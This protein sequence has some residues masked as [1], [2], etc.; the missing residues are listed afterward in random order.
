M[1][2]CGG[3]SVNHHAEKFC[4]CSEELGKA[5]VQLQTKRIDQAAFDKVRLEQEKCM[6]ESNPLEKFKNEKSKLEFQAAFLKAIFEQCPNV[7]RN[8]GFKE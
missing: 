6:G 3:P 1:A 4:S 2:S 8:M 7:A 5:T